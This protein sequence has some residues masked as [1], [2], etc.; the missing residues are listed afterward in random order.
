MDSAREHILS[1][2]RASQGEGGGDAAES[3]AAIQLPHPQ[4]SNAP[5]TGLVDQFEAKLGQV[6]G[7]CGRVQSLDDVPDQ[8]SDYLSSMRGNLEV[9]LTPHADIAGL[10][11]HVSIPESGPR[12]SFRSSTIG[13]ESAL[14]WRRNLVNNRE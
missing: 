14:Y 2:I 9:V 5:E 6:Q 7:T 11:W 10:D 1:K 13:A 12:E 4:F 3:R 8:I